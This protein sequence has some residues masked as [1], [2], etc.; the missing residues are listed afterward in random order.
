M[1]QRVAFEFREHAFDMRILTFAVVN[2]D[3][4]QIPPFLSEA[5]Q[6]FINEIR[7]ALDVHT[8]VK[9]AACL[10]VTMKK[11]IV[12]HNSL[13]SQ[14]ESQND[15]ENVESVPT[16]RYETRQLYI[17]IEA[18]TINRTTNLIRCYRVNVFNKI[19]SRYEEALMQGSGFSLS[20]I[21][22]LEVQINRHDPLSGSSFIRLPQYLANKNAKLKEFFISLSNFFCTIN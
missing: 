3:F 19:M 22:A 20:E 17:Q 12:D 15:G 8:S 1:A 13:S 5:R 7:S 18:A 10:H 21:H 9:V 6:Y 2:R 16:L 11:L 4:T 14:A